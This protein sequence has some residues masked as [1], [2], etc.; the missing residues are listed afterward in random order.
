MQA[1]EPK[2]SLNIDNITTKGINTPAAADEAN[3][4][5]TT[6]RGGFLGRFAIPMIDA[7][8][9]SVTP[10][11]TMTLHENASSSIPMFIYNFAKVTRSGVYTRP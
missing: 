10:E 1:S 2:L 9:K 4:S 3:I 11:P 7:T 5:I 8:P 6:I